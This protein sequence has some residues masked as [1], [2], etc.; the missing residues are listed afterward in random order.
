MIP[1]HD[2]LYNRKCII[3]Y[4]LNDKF[5]T[6]YKGTFVA[7]R[8]NELHMSKKVKGIAPGMGYSLFPTLLTLCTCND[9]GLLPTCLPGMQC[10][11]IKADYVS[12]AQCWKERGTWCIAFLGNEELPLVDTLKC[13]VP[14][15]TNWQSIQLVVPYHWLHARIFSDDQLSN[16][17]N[18]RDLSGASLR[19]VFF[20]LH[21]KEIHYNEWRRG[22]WTRY[23]IIDLTCNIASI[24]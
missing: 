15:D 24:N 22:W 18:I 4:V 12:C 19:K 14:S 23:C 8:L 6:S 20:L 10:S 5:S 9:S 2:P 17:D 13:L 3:T 11:L 7:L 1:A 21:D 16:N